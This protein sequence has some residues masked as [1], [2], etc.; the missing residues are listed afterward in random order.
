MT[1]TIETPLAPEWSHFF[2]VDS[3]DG[4]PLAI[5]IAPDQA[6]YKALARR[7]DIASLQGLSADLKIKRVTGSAS[8]HVKG[9]LKAEVTQICVVSAEDVAT[10]IVDD[11]E[12]WYAEDN[13]AVSLAKAR[14]EKMLEKGHAEIHLTEEQ[15][16]PEPVIDGQIDLGELVT[17]YL[18][19]SINPYPRAEGA[20][21]ETIAAADD[22]AFSF[23]N[24]FAGLKEWKDKL[25]E[26]K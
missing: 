11:F 1:D 22:D 4:K 19:L 13:A 3:L 23:K 25:T 20:T 9:T 15:D 17:Q 24:P 5:T 18:S 14:K 21:H 16:D 2:D 6:L 8:I 26:G 12:A 10:Q 7:L